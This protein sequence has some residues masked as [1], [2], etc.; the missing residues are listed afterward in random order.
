MKRKTSIVLVTVGVTLITLILVIGAAG[1]YMYYSYR[2]KTEIA[3]VNGEDFGRS[4]DSNGCIN[5]SLRQF[6]EF[7]ENTFFVRLEQMHIAGFTSGC[8]D[9]SAEVKNLCDGV[10]KPTEFLRSLEWSIDKCNAAGVDHDGPANGIFRAI[11][12]KCAK[13]PQQTVSYPSR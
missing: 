13:K 4:T 6:R 5:E 1:G 2:S 7:K 10:P 12:T 9:T 11:E 8:L 3:R